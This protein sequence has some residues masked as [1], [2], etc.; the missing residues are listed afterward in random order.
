MSDEMRRDFEAFILAGN[1]NADVRICTIEGCNCGEYLLERVEFRWQ[2]YKAGR[3][4]LTRQLAEVTVQRDAMRADAE[5]YRWLNENFE[6]AFCKGTCD[7]WCISGESRTLSFKNE[8]LT[9]AIDAARKET[10]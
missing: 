4:D 5:R 8:T 1:P 7:Y 9:D 10:K 6:F 2:G 3:A